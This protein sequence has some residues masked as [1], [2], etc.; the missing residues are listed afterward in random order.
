[1]DE[2]ILNHNYHH[3]YLFLFVTK[4]IINFDYLFI[5]IL[6]DQNQSPFHQQQ[7]QQHHVPSTVSSFTNIQLLGHTY[8]QRVPSYGY[9]YLRYHQPESNLIKF[10]LTLP[11][12]QSSS[13]S[14]SSSFSI[15]SR[16]DIGAPSILA[17]Y[18]NRDKPATHTRYDFVEFISRVL[19]IPSLMYH[20][21]RSKR[22]SNPSLSSSMTTTTTT[23]SNKPPSIIQK[24]FTKYLDNGIWFLTLYND[25]PTFIDVQLD[26]NLAN[27]ELCPNNCRGHGVCVAGHCECD[28]GYQGESCEPCKCLYSIRFHRKFLLDFKEEKKSERNLVSVFLLEF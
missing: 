27:E 15:N 23:Q 25:A 4:L 13:S 20:Q 7:S 12:S 24:K 2:N 16:G 11:A 5:S 14:S 22:S 28:P 1:M 3:Y 18:G 8:S 10:N 6:G 17:F 21:K 19:T 26:L 9:W